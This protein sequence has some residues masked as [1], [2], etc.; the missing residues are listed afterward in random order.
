MTH[1]S[2]P[3]TITNADAGSS[4]NE[5]LGESVL[6]ACIEGYQKSGGDTHLS[7]QLTE[8]YKAE[9]IGTPLKCSKGIN[10][11]FNAITICIV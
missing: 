1:C 5:S 11:Y 8:S 3:P 9:W 4:K 2:P 6:Y 10:Y 7:C